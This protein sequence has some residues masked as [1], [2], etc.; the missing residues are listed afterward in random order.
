M[1]DCRVTKLL[2]RLC[3]ALLPGLAAL[4]VGCQ[5]LAIPFLMWGREPTRT[6]TAEYPYLKGERIAVA[7]WADH[8]TIFEFPNVQLELSS[9][10]ARAIEQNVKDAKLVHPRE[11]LD[12]QNRNRDWDRL[13]AARLAER[14]R[15]SR[16][17]PL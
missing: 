6:E 12:F 3:S 13:P 1:P 9:F 17:I 11:V 16:P 10:V 4:V 8:E 14:L 15:A 5:A 2:R 7:V